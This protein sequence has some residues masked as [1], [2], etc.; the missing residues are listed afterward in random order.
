MDEHE[1]S[2][3]HKESALEKMDEHEKS[4]LHKESVLK[5]SAY[6]SETEVGVQLSTQ[7]STDQKSINL[8]FLR[9]FPPFAF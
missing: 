1:K 2:D 4:D 9:L 3:L 5:H 8:C 6:I 7:L